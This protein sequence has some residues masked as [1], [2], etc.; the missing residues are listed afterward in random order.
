MSPAF[1]SKWHVEAQVD[2]PLQTIDG[3]EDRIEESLALRA[4]L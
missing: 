4:P 3:F 1:G 2:K